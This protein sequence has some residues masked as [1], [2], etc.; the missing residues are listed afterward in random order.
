M[1][2]INIQKFINNNIDS[3]RQVFNQ[4][5]HK[6][7]RLSN[8][9][10]FITKVSE[11][12]VY[13]NEYNLDSETLSNISD[14]YND[15]L[16]FLANYGYKELTHINYTEL[17]QNNEK[18]N[19]FLDDNWLSNDPNFIEEL[20]KDPNLLLENFNNALKI[21]DIIKRSCTDGKPDEWFKTVLTWLFAN[22]QSHEQFLQ[23]VSLST[24]E[25]M[26]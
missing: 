13:V 7:P 2:K 14:K 17:T 12:D 23:R 5:A 15:F 25:M 1:L 8:E 19:R 4:Y 22:K 16:M 6:Y 18:L 11:Y 20:N 9:V 10:D 24:G 21:R 3:I 26:L